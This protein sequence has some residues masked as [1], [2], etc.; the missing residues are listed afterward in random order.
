[1]KEKWPITMTELRMQIA[2][3]DRQRLLKALPNV[4]GMEVEIRIDN[5]NAGNL[6]KLIAKIERWEI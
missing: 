1:M 2:E 5:F 6:G 4:I 3:E